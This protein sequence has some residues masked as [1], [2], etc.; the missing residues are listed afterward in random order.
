METIA[1]SVLRSK[2]M[3]VL[4]EIESGSTINITSRGKVIARLVPPGFS[5]KKAKDKLRTIG[6]T[7]VLND[8]M[9]PIDDE[10]KAE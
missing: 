4:R 6:K 5:R 10:W 8:L 3:R 1:V 7:A 2:L 9:S